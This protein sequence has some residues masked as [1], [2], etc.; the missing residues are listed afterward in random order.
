MLPETAEHVFPAGRY[1]SGL[2]LPNTAG[3][4]LLES[5]DVLRAIAGQIPRNGR[6]LELGTWCGAAAAWIADARP[7]ATIIS[8][9]TFQDHAAGPFLWWLNARRNMRL[10]VGTGASF[11]QLCR[12]GGFDAVLVDGDH[13]EAGVSED[14]RLAVSVLAP[15]G[16]ILAHDYGDPAWPGIRAAV[17]RFLAGGAWGIAGQVASLVVLRELARSDQPSHGAQER[18]AE[19]G[20]E[21]EAENGFV[22][23]RWIARRHGR[24]SDLSRV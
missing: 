7:D 11:C 22:R 15:G 12:A 16:T 23:S 6:Y 2:Y 3:P 18:A 5:L 21:Q 9:D 4:A 20:E 10:F 17:D 8:V 19:P 14:L 24:R 1:E 13:R